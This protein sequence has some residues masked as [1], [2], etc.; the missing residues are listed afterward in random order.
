VLIKEDRLVL[1]GPAV[2][3]ERFQAALTDW[4]RAGGWIV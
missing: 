2:Q 1:R 4:L 3:D